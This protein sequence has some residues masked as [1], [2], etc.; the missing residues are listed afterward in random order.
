MAVGRGLQVA[1]FAVLLAAVALSF[2]GLVREPKTR[3]NRAGQKVFECTGLG[4]RSRCQ[5]SQRVVLTATFLSGPDSVVAHDTRNLLKPNNTAACRYTVVESTEDT[6]GERLSIR[7][8][9]RAGSPGVVV[10]SKVPV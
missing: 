2:G 8:L 1:A 3:T 5:R 10:P 4:D 9:I 6:K 7:E